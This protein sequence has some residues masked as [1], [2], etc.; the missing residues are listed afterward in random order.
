MDVLDN[1][2]LKEHLPFCHTSGKVD[3]PGFGG[4]DE[5]YRRLARAITPRRRVIAPPRTQATLRPYYAQRQPRVVTVWT[6][7]TRRTRVGG[8][9]ASC[10]SLSSPLLQSSED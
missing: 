4:H 7:P 3:N 1:P 2:R 10:W 8:V 6:W 9:P 5:R